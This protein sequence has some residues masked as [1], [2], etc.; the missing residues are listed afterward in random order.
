MS[1]AAVCLQVS[2]SLGKAGV[3]PSPAGTVAGTQGSGV[4]SK[5]MNAHQRRTGCS[6]CQDRFRQ[7]YPS[8]PGHERHRI[9]TELQLIHKECERLGTETKGQHGFSVLTNLKGKWK[10]NFLK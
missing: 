3:T 4:H 6:S 5:G 1:C 8:H 9:I 7:L 2:A 10:D